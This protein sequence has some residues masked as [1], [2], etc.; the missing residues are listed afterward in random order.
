MPARFG[1]VGT[2]DP[3]QRRGTGTDAGQRLTLGCIGFAVAFLFSA[4]AAEGSAIMATT[5]N[6]SAE[7]VVRRIEIMSR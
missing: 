2:I 7:A 6:R 5:A 3:R 4:S 1:W